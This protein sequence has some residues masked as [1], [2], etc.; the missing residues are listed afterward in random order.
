MLGWKPSIGHVWSLIKRN[1]STDLTRTKS[2]TITEVTMIWKD[3]PLNYLQTLGDSL[4]NHL[5]E[6]IDTKGAYIFLLISSL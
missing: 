2:D 1:R 4:P 6:V 3:I 5:Q